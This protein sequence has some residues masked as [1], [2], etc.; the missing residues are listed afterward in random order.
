[1]QASA[2][3]AF[4]N[5]ETGARLK[6][7][8]GRR[9]VRVPSNP[10][11]HKIFQIHLPLAVTAYGGRFPTNTDI[12]QD[13]RPSIVIS[14]LILAQV[15]H[16]IIPFFPVLIP[17]LHGVKSSFMLASKPLTPFDLIIRQLTNSLYS[18]H[19]SPSYQM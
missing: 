8:F 16:K 4:G 10:L 2:G 19:T 6:Y 15:K 11:F 12:V 7:K 17:F 3:F 13:F 18:T 9:G 5:N 1:M 14:V